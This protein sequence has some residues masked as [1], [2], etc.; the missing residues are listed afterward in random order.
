MSETIQID[1]GESANIELTI[2]D[3]I[4][5]GGTPSSRSIIA[6]AGLTGGGDLTAD[7]TLAVGAHVDGSIVVAADTVQ[8]GILATDAQHGSRGGAAL[9]SVASTSL[10]GFMS[11]A[12]K[13]KLDSLPASATP[14]SRTITAGA[15]L[16]GGG[17]L[18]V[19]RTLTVG[20][21]ADGSIV[22]NADE[23][24]VGTLATD[25]QHGNRGGGAL[26][27]SAVASGA[28]GFITGSD[29]AKLDGV[30]SG[31]TANLGDVVGPV[32]ST[33]NA[34][35]RFDSTTG[36][37]LQNSA[38]TIDDSG[39]IATSGTIDGRD[40]STDG[41]KLDTITVANIPSATEKAALA[42]TGTPSGSN[43]FVTN[44]DSRL[45]DTRT[46]TD[47]TVTTVKIVDANV[48]LAKMANLA[49][50]TLIGRATASTG[51]PET[52]A[53]TAAGRAII[54]DADAS[55]QRTTLGL[56]TLA[57]QSGTF[58]GTSSGTNTGD[59]T[60]IS[61]N[62]ATVTTNANLTGPVTSV[63]NAT[64]ITADAVSNAMLANM[65]AHTFKGNNT[66]SSD[67][68][69]D[70]TAT[71]A[72]AELNAVVG[73]SGSGGTKGLVP[74]PAS[75]DAAAGKVLSAD[76]TWS[77]YLTQRMDLEYFGDYSDGD[78]T[79]SSGT[80]TLTR[81]MFYRDITPSGTAQIVMNGF[82]IR[83]RN[84]DLSNAPANAIIASAVSNAGGNAV[85]NTAGSAGVG[86][87]NSGGYGG[88][89][90]G[91]A[92]IGGSN[93][94]GG[95]GGA[96]LSG[97]VYGG[98][99]GIAG[100]GG[101]N[102]AGTAGGSPGSQSQIQILRSTGS[103]LGLIHSA[104]LAVSAS[105]LAAHAAAGGSGSAGCAGRTGVTSG[106]LG[107]G[108]GGAGGGGLIMI[109]ARTITRGASTAGGCISA[110]GGVGG[111]GGD[112][113]TIVN[114]GGGGS[115]AGGGGG[116]F[117]CLTYR[118]LSGSAKSGALLATGG[119]G[120]N[121]GAGGGA[122]AIGGTGGAGGSGGVV[123]LNDIAN[124]TVTNTIG[125]AGSAA[126]VASTQSGTTGGAAGTCSVTL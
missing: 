108:G 63:G 13:T 38:V 28:A 120:G 5:S 68:P 104:L 86:Q 29:K 70:L 126:T 9:H 40:V 52:I 23:I 76:G 77:V 20:A 90:R 50:D 124:N 100:V 34:I 55:A 41:I 116:G 21:N 80:T 109:F 30:A 47:G 92:G 102:N 57:T 93:I 82:E 14:T 49:Q 65:A 4:S 27:A 45:T 91:L 117:I 15:G 110:I 60:N 101:A 11:A 99:G 79:V 69:L 1:I 123:Q 17:D 8:V 122:A 33:D 71:Q 96:P 46:P 84:L 73:D 3:T 58:S 115:G 97:L 6:G 43:K 94:S 18:S 89:G 24:Q 118:I 31:A 64:T 35:A 72:T 61:G 25:G 2:A 44:D 12:D 121:G 56:G 48:T 87:G 7:R 88:I 54:D 81:N 66:G 111:N 119:V 113:T 75:G 85:A 22:V 51:V 125:S 114:Q 112:G 74:A 67:N 42:G 36:K 78:L 59:Q 107:A 16:T 39:N 106:T 10:A 26:H 98:L 105:F 32:S 53:L 95:S 103:S 83:C 19:D 37:L 62:A